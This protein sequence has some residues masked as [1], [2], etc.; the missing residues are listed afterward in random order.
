MVEE[1]E[2]IPPVLRLSSILRFPE[3]QA[4]ESVEIGPLESNP[5]KT[6]TL[7]DN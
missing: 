6:E 5:I 3:I 4:V 1:N 7:P 2:V